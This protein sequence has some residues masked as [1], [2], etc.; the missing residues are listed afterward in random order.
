MEATDG[1]RERRAG[2]EPGRVLVDVAVAVA[3]GAV[4]ISDVQTLADQ[5]GLHGPAGSV[6]STPTIWRVLDAVAHT[7]GMLAKIRLARAEARDR[8]WL[9]RGEL[10]GTEL[11][12][13]RAAGTTI[14]QVVIDL[15]AT[16]VIAHSDKEGARGN[17]KG[18]FGYHPLGAW[19]DNTGEALA[20]LLR[21][22]NAGSSNTAADHLTVVDW[23]LTQ[24]P[25]RW[26]GKP[27]LIR[28]DGA[29]YSHAFISALSQQGLEFSVGYPVT[30]TVLD[31]IKKVP[32]WAWQ[33]A[34]NADGLLREPADVID[35]THMLD[36][37]KWTRSCP[38]MR[39][40]VP[41]APAS[42]GDP[43]RLRDPRRLPLPGLHHQHPDR[44][45]RVARSPTP[46]ARPRRRPRPDRQGHLPSRHQNIN[47]VWTELA[48]I[49]ADLLARAQT[50]LLTT[51]PELHRVEPK[52]LRYRL[53]HTA[54]RITHGQRKVFLRLAEHWPWALALA[55]AFQRLRTIPLPA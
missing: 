40:I 21:P 23:A 34:S 19:L 3:D 52:T 31:A 32:K 12:G 4:T 54:A 51:E 36:L 8:A 33:V 26:R 48:L 11:P 55:K 14:S 9:A 41:G 38:D 18:G 5:Q 10:T 45:T 47:E 43:G 25:D 39:V 17:F 37:S 49:A 7:P 2:H 46:G 1:L 24:L 53:L 50:M 29:G 22:G 28:A 27:V 35:I 20:A 16:L 42:R 30:E 6:A 44:A 15:D 13:S